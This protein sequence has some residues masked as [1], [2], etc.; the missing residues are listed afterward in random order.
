M[1]KN[2][3][4]EA[5]IDLLT[6]TD[7]KERKSNVPKYVL[8]VNGYVSQTRADSKE[9]I[10]EATVAIKLR[11]PSAKIEVYEFAFTSD[12]DFPTT[13]VQPQTETTEVTN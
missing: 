9:D 6:A 2:E 4:R 7:T 10:R 12:L 3:I 1:N 11:N 13:E 8:V 5:L